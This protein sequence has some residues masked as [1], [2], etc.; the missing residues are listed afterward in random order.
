MLLQSHV[1]AATATEAL[2][3]R[4]VSYRNPG[5]AVV[6]NNATL[7]QILPVIAASGLEADELFLT[8][9][10][11]ALSNRSNEAALFTQY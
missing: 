3:I 6:T 10:I 1:S 2:L 5:A 11:C 9:M 4:Q 8:G 7:A